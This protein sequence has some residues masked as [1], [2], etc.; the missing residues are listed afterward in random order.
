[1]PDAVAR[2]ASA[3][4]S[5]ASRSSNILHRRIAVAGIDEAG[6]FAGEARVG[7]LGAV[8][9]EALGQIER[10]GGLAVAASAPGRRAPG[11]W[12]LPSRSGLRSCGSASGAKS[13]RRKGVGRPFAVKSCAS[14]CQRRRRPRLSPMHERFPR[15][16]ALPVHRGADRRAAPSPPRAPFAADQVQPASLDLRLGARAWRVRASFLP[17]PRPGRSP[18]GSPDVAMHELDLTG[19]G[20]VLERGCVYIAELQERLAL[21]PGVSARANP[22]ELHRPGRRLR[23]PAHRRPARPSTTSPPATPDRCIWRS[24][25]RPSRCWCAP[26]RGSTSCG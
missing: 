4:S 12:R 19:G 11:G 5:S 1:M 22:E 16:P 13:G 20:A 6:L 8:V 25:R 26:A 14:A 21:P 10:L 2:Q 24:R 15:H 9:D 7:L 23:A 18:S 17:R 3:P